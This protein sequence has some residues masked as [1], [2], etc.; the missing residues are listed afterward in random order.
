MPPLGSW[1]EK[2]NGKTWISGSNCWR[3]TV[4]NHSG[5]IGGVMQYGG[6]GGHCRSGTIH[7]GAITAVARIQPLQL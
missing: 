4:E 6:R 3:A 2:K 7:N 5:N 1:K